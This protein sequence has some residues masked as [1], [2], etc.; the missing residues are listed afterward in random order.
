MKENANVDVVEFLRTA[1]SFKSQIEILAK[2][3]L[4]DEEIQL[5]NRV[6][7]EIRETSESYIK[8]RYSCQYAI[9][10]VECAGI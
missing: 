3:K 4:P 2:S 6:V 8:G 9:E 7:K 1:R 10:I 5:M